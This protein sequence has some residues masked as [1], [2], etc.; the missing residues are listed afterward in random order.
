MYK[1]TSGIALMALLGVSLT[2]CT[3][4]EAPT[5]TATKASKAIQYELKHIITKSFSIIFTA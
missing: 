2:A 4:E 1:Y 3:K 5:E